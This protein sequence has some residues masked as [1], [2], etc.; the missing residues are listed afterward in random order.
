MKIVDQISAANNQ[1]AFASQ[2]RQSPADLKVE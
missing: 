1:D 2:W